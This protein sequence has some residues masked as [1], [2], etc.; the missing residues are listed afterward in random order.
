MITTQ[1]AV[2]SLRPNI[3]W[4]MNGDDVEGIIWHTPDV[5]PLTTAE[6]EA[7]IKRLKKAEADK[8]K[9][10][11]AAIAA[12]IA[13]AKSLGFTDAMIAVMYPTLTP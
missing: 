13:H 12:A 8:V 3:E 6:V 4:S 10:D 7:E 5:E 1:Q 9:A 2:M 11:A